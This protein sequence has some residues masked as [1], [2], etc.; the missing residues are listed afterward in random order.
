MAAPTP[1]LDII[2]WD[3][4]QGRFRF[5]AKW[6][7]GAADN[8]TDQNIVDISADLASAPTSVK[9]ESLDVVVNGNVEVIF[10]FDATTDQ[11][12]YRFIGQTDATIN[13]KEDFTKGPNGGIVPSDTGAAGFTGDILLTTTGAADGDEVIVHGVFKK[14]TGS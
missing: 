6:T 9:V 4:Y 2:N 12:I 7:A 8:Y 1:A 5:V 3:G 10:E 14:S 11:E 13:F